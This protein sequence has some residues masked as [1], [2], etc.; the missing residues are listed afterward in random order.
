MHI[1]RLS[2][3]FAVAV[4]LSGNAIAVAVEDCR[5]AYERQDVLSRREKGTR[6]AVRGSAGV[7]LLHVALGPRIAFS[8]AS[9]C[10][11]V[12]APSLSFCFSRSTA[13]WAASAM[14]RS[15]CASKSCRAY[16]AI[17]VSSMGEPP[18]T[19]H[20]RASAAHVTGLRMGPSTIGQ[21]TRRRRR[22]YRRV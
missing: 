22:H 2:V 6:A 21:I 19:G 13:R 5:A 11:Q 18:S 7:W 10:R 15:P 14:A 17:T 12:F 4:L 20:G 16:S 3:G 9:T 1:L 8:A